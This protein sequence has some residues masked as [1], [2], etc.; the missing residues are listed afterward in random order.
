MGSTNT[1]ID[2]LRF[3]AH[4]PAVWVEEDDILSG[5]RPRF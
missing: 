5:K 3:F 4:L 2:T 1:T